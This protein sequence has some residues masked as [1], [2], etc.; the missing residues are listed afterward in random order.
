MGLRGDGRRGR[1]CD[2]PVRPAGERR[3]RGRGDDSSGK[4]RANPP[5]PSFLGAD[6]RLRPGHSVTAGRYRED[7]R[8][9][10][11]ITGFRYV[12]FHGILD[13]EVG[14]YGKDAQGQAVY[15]FSYLDDIF[16]GLLANGVRPFVE[17]SFMPAA[18]AASQTPHGFWYRPL[19]KSTERLW[20]LERTGIPG[21]A[22]RHGAV[23]RE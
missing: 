8:A 15:N 14:V 13:D 18:L 1:H 21:G 16:D 17:L 4:G 3:S 22:S 20:A 19:A 7:L 11:R 2:L 23:W 6:V 5:I 12:R 9:T 10:R